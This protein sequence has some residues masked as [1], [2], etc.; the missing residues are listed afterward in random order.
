MPFEV[1]FLWIFVFFDIFLSLP[2]KSLSSLMAFKTPPFSNYFFNEWFSYPPRWIFVIID[3]V[4]YQSPES[5]SWWMPSFQHHR[6]L[7]HFC[8]WFSLNDPPESVSWSMIFGISLD[9]AGSASWQ[10]PCQRE[11]TLA[12]N[13]GR[14]KNVQNCEEGEAWSL[15]LKT[16]CFQLVAFNLLPRLNFPW[17]LPLSPQSRDWG[18]QEVAWLM[19][20]LFL[21]IDFCASMITCLLYSDLPLIPDRRGIYCH[22]PVPSRSV[23][24]REEIVK[25]WVPYSQAPQDRVF[26]QKIEVP[27]FDLSRDL[28]KQQF[29]HACA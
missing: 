20:Q 18:A 26:L 28:E 24:R 15:F 3:A 6:R 29:L 11:Q 27:S 7:I 19:L 22:S 5:L 25:Y 8:P 12:C 17:F 9:E 13:F 16:C 2:A 23:G 10:N 14:R 1:S 4:Q 21:W